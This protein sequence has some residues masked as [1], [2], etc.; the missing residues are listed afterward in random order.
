MPRPLQTHT[1][2]SGHAGYGGSVSDSENAGSGARRKPMKNQLEETVKA[3]AE[4]AKFIQIS[5]LALI[6]ELEAIYAATYEAIYAATC[7]PRTPRTWW[8]RRT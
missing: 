7:A 5:C 1:F 4:M 3:R 2:S 6:S 8:T